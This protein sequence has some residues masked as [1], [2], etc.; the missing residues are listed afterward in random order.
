MEKKKRPWQRPQIK[1]VKLTINEAVLSVCKVTSAGVGR[2]SR[3]CGVNGCR[4]TLG[5]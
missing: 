3:T 2:T 5:S 1:Q 4:T